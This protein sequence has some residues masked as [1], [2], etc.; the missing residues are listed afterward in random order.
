MDVLPSKVRKSDELHREQHKNPGSL[1][2][3]HSTLTFRVLH[4]WKTK[5]AGSETKKTLGR[6][7][8]DN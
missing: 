5:P 4:I 3:E 8:H 2:K 6:P 7:L 1:S